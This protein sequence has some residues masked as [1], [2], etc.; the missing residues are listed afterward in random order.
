MFN[1]VLIEPQIPQNTGN[2]ARTCACAG[3]KLHLIKPLFDINDKTLK[4]AGLDYWDKLEIFYYKD[5]DDFFNK[6]QGEYFFIETGG[7]QNYTQVKFYK[8]AYLFFGK[9]TT[10]IDKQI[11][12]KY[13]DRIISIPMSKN[14]RSL[15]LSNCVALVL[16]EALRQNTFF[17]LC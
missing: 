10:G 1:I 4:R 14:L 11:L 15:N 3:A 16:Y 12:N 17:D 6:N 2:I 8:D 5:A 7:V 13:E 9:E